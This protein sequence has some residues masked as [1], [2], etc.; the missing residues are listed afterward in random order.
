[1]R[2][3][4]YNR[5]MEIFFYLVLLISSAVLIIMSGKTN[6][7]TD[8]KLIF[9]WWLIN[10]VLALLYVAIKTRHYYAYHMKRLMQKDGI[11]FLFLTAFT[12][13]TSFFLLDQYPA[14]SLGDELRDAGLNALKIKQGIITDFFDF[15]SYQGYGNFIP[16]ISSVFIPFFNL[17]P[18]IYRIPSALFGT[19]AVLLTYMLGRV[20]GGR[21]V[22]LI[23]A[24]FLAGSLLHL[25]YSRTELLVIV[26]SF[27][28]PIVIMTVLSALY[29]KE[30]FF[31][32][33]LAAGFSLHF[34]A[35]I[36]GIIAASL[37]YLIA[38][39]LIRFTSLLKK[40]TI[41]IYL[42]KIIV[43]A[44]LF[45]IGFTVAAG[46]TITKLKD[47]NTY[48]AV[49]TTHLI[50]QSDAFQNK[51]FQEKIINLWDL[52]QQ[53]FLTYTFKPTNDF[54]FRYRQS[55]KEPLLPTPLNWFFLTG[56]VSV[57][58]IKRLRKKHFSSLLIMIILV[59]PIFNEVAVNTVGFDHRLMSVMP[60]LM[61]VAALGINALITAIPYRLLQN[62]FIF[63]ILFIY[64][65]SQLFLFFIQRVSDYGFDPK[66]YVF[67]EMLTYIKND[68]SYSIYFIAYNETNQ[69]NLLHYQEKALFFTY[70][71]NVFI[72]DENQFAEK[73]NQKYAGAISSAAFLF[74][75]P[76]V[77][78]NRYPVKEVIKNCVQKKYVP[79]YSC[80]L[81]FQGTLRFYLL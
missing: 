41:F 63:G 34:Y 71:K 56:L 51:T 33:G 62:L 76:F 36:R 73:L 57:F 6:F 49:G 17:S 22:G 59:F 21:R 52:Y 16:L 20:A 19:G 35:G 75:Q 42:K 14:I 53:S 4:F 44:S 67:Q 54:H 29:Q 72:I 15:G 30:G 55:H 65:S 23:A 47:S 25:H 69:L 64:L 77:Q 78:I 68:Q 70:P 28:A 60:T 74:T 10:F 40:G 39:H 9:T 48:A 66:E 1:M 8:T 43:G 18:L 32:T 50:F 27:L 80:P 5:R 7:L 46:P 61:V 11:T 24:L 38:F 37:L 2:I 31:L 79:D 26:D 12:I 3:S 81:H 13:L 45:V 58:M